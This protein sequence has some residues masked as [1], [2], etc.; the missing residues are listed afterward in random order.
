MP[1]DR[2]TLGWFFGPK[3]CSLSG[4]GV[5]DMPALFLP[6]LFPAD[7]AVKLM[8]IMLSRF[9]GVWS[10]SKLYLSAVAAWHLKEGFGSVFDSVRY[11]DKFAMFWKGM[12]NNADHTGYAKRPLEHKEVCDYVSE[13]VGQKV[14]KGKNPTKAGLRDCAAM[15]VAFFG[16]RRVAEVVALNVGHVTWSDQG[17]HVLIERQKNSDVPMT[18]FIPFMPKADFCPASLLKQWQNTVRSEYSLKDDDPLFIVTRKPNSGSRL[19]SAALR[20]AWSVAFGDTAVSTHSC[21]KGGA[22]WW[23]QQ[24]LGKGGVQKQG[25]WKT[26]E[27][28]DKIYLLLSEE[29]TM[30]K[31]VQIGLA[32]K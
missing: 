28:M 9:Q 18:C 11:S 12:K 19:T 20:Q 21:R 27:T 14:A 31:M 32:A 24:G 2:S 29:S 26:T 7:T 30:A 25:G 15:V 4:A 22:Q 10:T 13:R 23:L 5:L 8:I 17:A 16:V 6:P 3:S 1:G